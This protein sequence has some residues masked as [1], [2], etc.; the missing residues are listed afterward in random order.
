MKKIFCTLALIIVLVCG[1]TSCDFPFLPGTETTATTPTET[2]PKN[3][4]ELLP[5]KKD[6]AYEVNEDGETCTITNI[7]ACTDRKLYIGG[8]I[9]G[10]KITAIGDYAFSFCS[11]ITSVTIGDYV[12]TI[13]NDAFSFCSSLM[14]V[15]IGDY[16]TTIGNEAFS[17][18]SR[19][20]SVTIGDSVTTIGEMAFQSCS[21]LTSVTIGNSVT[22]I[23]EAAFA[24]CSKLT[25]V[26][27]GDSV[28]TIGEYAFADCSYL[29]DLIISDSVTTIGEWAFVSCPNLTSV[30]IPDSVTVIGEY[31]FADCS[32]LTSVTF[33]NPNGWWCAS[34]ANT[35]KGI[36]ISADS[37]SDTST[38]ARYLTYKYLGD[39]WFRTE[40]TEE[41]PE[42]PPVGTSAGKT[43]PAVSLDIVGS[44]EK[45]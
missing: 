30:T 14:R 15:T 26:T 3:T 23:G 22:T 16:V 11:T 12:T 20:T 25:S 18:C 29:T 1:L 17:F 2:T 41:S 4:E 42:K 40:E 35:T 7:G 24:D 6:L 43:C 27:I 10:Y 9:D 45:I 39:Y 33:A 36:A 31:A 37:L 21:R 34:N 5:A 32:Y 13:G 44:D 38:A 8:Y 28:T 19:L